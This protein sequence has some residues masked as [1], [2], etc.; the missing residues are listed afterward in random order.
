MAQPDAKDEA[1]IAQPQE[2]DNPDLT[3]DRCGVMA[4]KGYAGNEEWIDLCD[5][6]FNSLKEWF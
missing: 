3:C 4:T 1:E 5:S 6:C 2:Y